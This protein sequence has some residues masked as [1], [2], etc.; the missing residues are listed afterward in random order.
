MPLVFRSFFRLLGAVLLLQAF[1]PFTDGHAQ[2]LDITPLG[3]DPWLSGPDSLT[4]GDY[5]L[6]H[7]MRVPECREGVPL[8]VVDIGVAIPGSD[9][10]LDLIVGGD[11]FYFANRTDLACR[12]DW[13]TYLDWCRGV[14]IPFMHGGTV[15]ADCETDADCPA[16]PNGFRYKCAKGYGICVTKELY[17]FCMNVFDPVLLPAVVGFC[18]EL[19]GDSNAPGA[20]PQFGRGFC[21]WIEGDHRCMTMLYD[22]TCDPDCVY[23]GNFPECEDPCDIEC[24]HQCN[25]NGYCWHR[26]NTFYDAAVEPDGQGGYLVRFLRDHPEFIIRRDAKIVP[27]VELFGVYPMDYFRD[28]AGA[29]YLLTDTRVWLAH[30]LDSEIDF[31]GLGVYSL[32]ENRRFVFPGYAKLG[33]SSIIWKKDERPPNVRPIAPNNDRVAWMR[34]SSFSDAGI[35][36]GLRRTPYDSR[37]KRDYVFAIGSG[38]PCRLEDEL[39]LRSPH[40]GVA[41]LAR[42]RATPAAIAD[43][44]TWEYYDGMED[45]RPIWLPALESGKAHGQERARPV[46][47]YTGFAP[48]SI[49]RFHGE[50]WHLGAIPSRADKP[51][52]TLQLLRSPDGLNWFDGGSYPLLDREMPRRSE[53]VYSVRWLPPAEAGPDLGFL[54]SHWLSY[55]GYFM[56]PSPDKRFRDYNMKTWKLRPP[57]ARSFITH[58]NR[59]RPKPGGRVRLPF[60]VH[61]A[62]EESETCLAVQVCVCPDGEADCV[63]DC[64]PWRPFEG[65]DGGKENPWRWVRSVYGL[66]KGK[67]PDGVPCFAA[68]DGPRTENERKPVKMVLDWRWTE[69]LPSSPSVSAILRFALF[70]SD[71]ETPYEEMADS[72]RV[73]PKVF[74]RDW[75]LWQDPGGWRTT[76][77]IRFRV[78]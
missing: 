8:W 1:H 50:L 4:N 74:E 65:A 66:E 13:K 68:P 6:P 40:T 24:H 2:E 55:E 44:R 42:I 22:D 52:D 75:R 64:R 26:N 67:C 56:A 27:D 73:I 32:T 47:S 30:D 61:P 29:T 36:H 53:F 21:D 62:P 39:C 41:R 16:V 28:E 31:A 72:T 38:P 46:F 11:T 70:R 78:Q 45:G 10:K 77:P 20:L 59:Y 76:E 57:E 14:E 17:D 48:S 3:S 9:G 69:D 19:R 54:L 37:N 35:V 43:P 12:A 23:G 49:I 33:P 51:A 60:H 63:R 58:S 7:P 34:G 5:K 15:F 25:R 18:F 71:S